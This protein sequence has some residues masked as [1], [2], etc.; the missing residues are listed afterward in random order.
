VNP[1]KT[2]QGRVAADFRSVDLHPEEAAGHWQAAVGHPGVK[3]L[4]MQ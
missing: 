3:K 1:G 4:A 2:G